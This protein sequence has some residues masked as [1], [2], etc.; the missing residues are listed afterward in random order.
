MNA[1]EKTKYMTEVTEY[2]E[3]KKVYS[4]F[5]DLYRS[6]S[7]EQPEDPLKFMINRLKTTRREVIRKTHLCHRL[8][9]VQH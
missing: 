8:S 2:L 7:I 6:L 3:T 9:G 5:E 4:I 1:L